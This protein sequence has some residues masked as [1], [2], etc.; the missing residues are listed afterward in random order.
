M[1]LVPIMA[2]VRKDLQLFFSDRR[3]VI[4]SFVVPIVIASFFGSIMGSNNKEPAPIAIG[5]VDEDGSTI[6]KALTTAA[7]GDKRV[8][9]A[10]AGRDDAKGRVREGKLTVAV[11][12]PA[13]FGEQSGRALFSGAAKPEL[14]LLVDPSRGAEVALVRGILTEHTMQAVTRDMFGGKGGRQIVDETLRQVD[15]FG[16]PP[17][18]AQLLKEMLTTV[19]R[20]YDSSPQR[21]GGGGG[22]G[23][24]G[25]SM[26]YTLREEAVTA[27]DLVAF[28]AYAHAFA[29][30]G[31][32]FLLFA[33][34]NLGIA[35]LLERQRGLWKRL[36]SAP[37]SRGVLLGAKIV[38]GA[39]VSLLTLLISFAF[40]MAMFGVRISGSPLG[41]VL[42]AA[43]CSIMSATFGLLVAALGKTEAS[44][45]GVAILAVLLM[46]MLGGAWVPTFIFP[47]WLQRLTVVIPVRWAVDGLDAVTW[48]GLG[49][50]SALMPTL[51][52]L[53]FAAVFGTIA[54]ARF[55]W[56]EI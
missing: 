9:V 32:Q 54:L 50:S 33:S 26:P 51:T 23:G 39:I 31:I 47:G 35:M 41:F 48:R 7:Q 56:E 21:D 15:G 45:R 28:N 36:R 18:Q 13:G 2:L 10:I 34:T 1:D 52:L 16:M 3:A 17:A 27:R 12:I 14:Q 30:M 29:G 8:G 49:L 5:I 37:L 6:S 20:F 11:V 46:V 25:F 38:S 53:A 43:A 19:R 22:G 42:V 55:R 40:A 4:V 24:V 44:A